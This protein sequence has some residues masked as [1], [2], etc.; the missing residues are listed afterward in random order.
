MLHRNDHIAHRVLV[1]IYIIIKKKKKQEQETR[2]RKQEKE[3]EKIYSCGV[4]F[5]FF[6]VFETEQQNNSNEQKI[7]TQC[8]L[9]ISTNND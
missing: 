4:S 6:S 8:Y 7:S 3:I 9:V 2:N 1:H 5:L